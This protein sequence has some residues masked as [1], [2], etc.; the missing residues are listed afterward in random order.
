MRVASGPYRP[1]KPRFEER[2][3]RTK[4]I[5]YS[6]S[7]TATS[8]VCG[9]GRANGLTTAMIRGVWLSRRWF[10]NLSVTER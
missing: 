7:L 1:V 9:E 8:A 4:V 2:R 5:A 3:T 10:G 6:E